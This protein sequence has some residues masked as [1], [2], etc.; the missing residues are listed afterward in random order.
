ML[1][2]IVQ[3]SWPPSEEIC[4]DKLTCNFLNKVDEADR[5]LLACWRTRPPSELSEPTDERVAEA[6][7][8]VNSF[9]LALNTVEL[10]GPQHVADVAEGTVRTFRDELRTILDE[11]LKHASEKDMLFT[12][13]RKEFRKAYRKR[14][15]IKKT[16]I[17]AARV[18]LDEAPTI[19]SQDLRK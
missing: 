4:G 14:A 16:L 13:A 19:V 10:E 6:E 1:Q 8:S 2:P 11:R 12:L 15:H 17:D 7:Q 3:S 5:L 18:A 9:G